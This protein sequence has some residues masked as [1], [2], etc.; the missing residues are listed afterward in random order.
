MNNIWIFADVHLGHRRLCTEFEPV[1]RPFG[2]PEEHDQFVLSEHNKL[3]KPKDTVWWLGDIAFG[4]ESLELVRRFNGLKRLVM[5]NHDQYPIALYQTMFASVHAM[6]VATAVTKRDT[7]FTHVPIHPSQFYRY[8][9]NVHGHIHGKNLVDRRYINV[10]LEQTG[11]RPVLLRDILKQV[12]A[13]P[14]ADCQPIHRE[15]EPT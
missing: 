15:E 2:S 1:T 6:L 8:R 14:P 4:K 3:V 5:G 12:A 10:S 7:L 11:L 13:L 9:A